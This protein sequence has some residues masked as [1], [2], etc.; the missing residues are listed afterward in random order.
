MTKTQDKFAVL[1]A[2][3]AKSCYD[4]YR[5][6][7]NQRRSNPELRRITIGICLMYRKHYRTWLY[8]NR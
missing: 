5:S 3:E 1:R 8:Y 2:Q 6:E 7:L 4:Y